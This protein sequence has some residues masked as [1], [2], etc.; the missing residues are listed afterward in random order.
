MFIC[1]I[2]ELTTAP[3]CQK[4]IIVSSISNLGG[5]ESLEIAVKRFG[6]FIIYFQIRQNY[7]GGISGIAYG[8]PDKTVNIVQK[9]QTYAQYC[10][11]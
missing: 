1:D 8:D 7:F 6:L 10:I 9:T 4:T 11:I 5:R 3:N 2:I